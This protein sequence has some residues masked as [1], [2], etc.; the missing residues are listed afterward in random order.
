[1]HHTERE[2]QIMRNHQFRALAGIEGCAEGFTDSG[3]CCGRPATDPIHTVKLSPAME[4]IYAVTLCL[5]YVP[6]GAATTTIVALM[7]RGLV[8]EM[9][10]G[11]GRHYLAHE[12]DEIH[13]TALIEHLQ[14]SRAAG[15]YRYVSQESW[16][17][18]INHMRRLW[19]L[20]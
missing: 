15:E 4:K 20:S 11:T 12:R 1:L 17:A 7:H 9:Q 16:D 5:G 2:E 18:M 6:T 13:G 19:S 3:P 14:R 8:R 10:P